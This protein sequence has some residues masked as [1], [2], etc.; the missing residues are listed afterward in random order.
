MGVAAPTLSDEFFRVEWTVR[1]GRHGDSRIIGYTYNQYQE[2]AEHVQLRLSEIDASGDAV[3]NVTRPV[4]GTVPALDRSSFDVQALAH[5]GVGPRYQVAVP[6]FDF[7][8][9]GR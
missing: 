6:S 4:F 7:L 1:L 3:S 9:R 5:F 8:E 2:P